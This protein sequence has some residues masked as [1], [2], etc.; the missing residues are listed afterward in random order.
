MQ[1]ELTLPIE[2][3]YIIRLK[4]NNFDEGNWLTILF[5]FGPR[6]GTWV[7][8]PTLNLSFLA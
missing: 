2:D 3:L 7:L 6:R 8:G 4:K 1:F 5:V